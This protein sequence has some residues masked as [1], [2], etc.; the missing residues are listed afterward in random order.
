MAD[1]LKDV[2]RLAFE[3]GFNARAHSKNL[4]EQ[5]ELFE[6]RVINRLPEYPRFPPRRVIVPKHS[7]ECVCYK[8]VPKGVK[9]DRKKA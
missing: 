2:M 5:L 3:A 4:P 7:P 1:P 9:Y 6:Q 8:C